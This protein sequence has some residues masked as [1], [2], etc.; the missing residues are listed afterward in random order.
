MG[1]YVKVV[2]NSLHNNE[3]MNKIRTYTC[4]NYTTELQLYTLTST[5]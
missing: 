3:N 2:N 1:V 4:E 5:H